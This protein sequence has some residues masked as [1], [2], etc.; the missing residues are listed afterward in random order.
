M[1]ARWGYWGGELFAFFCWWAQERG[2]CFNQFYWLNTQLESLISVWIFSL[3]E[4]LVSTE[5]LIFRRISIYTPNIRV[6]GGVGYVRTHYP[7]QWIHGP[8]FSM[9]GPVHGAKP[10][11]SIAHVLGCGLHL[12]NRA[13]PLPIVII[14]LAPYAKT[15]IFSHTSK[16]FED[17]TFFHCLYRWSYLARQSKVFQPVFTNWTP[18]LNIRSLFEIFSIL[19]ASISF[20]PLIFV[21]WKGPN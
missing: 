19:E 10:I 20:E 8:W 11:C 21:G 2:R 1:T 14:V 13:G 3:L 18:N 4:A 9:L 6:L 12:P 7:A 17:S 15:S 16:T 5:P